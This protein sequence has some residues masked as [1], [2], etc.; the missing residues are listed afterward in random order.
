MFLQLH[1]PPKTSTTC[2]LNHE[3]NCSNYAANSSLFPVT[4]QQLTDKIST[5]YL[6]Y[7]PHATH[8][9]G[10]LVVNGDESLWGVGRDLTLGRRYTQ[11]LTC[12]AVSGHSLSLLLGGMPVNPMCHLWPQTAVP[13]V[14]RDRRSPDKH[15]IGNVWECIVSM[16]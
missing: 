11:H 5:I 16:I 2:H 3:H 6:H 8:V 1:P 9:L 14:S 7:A 10:K 12:N 15:Y 4:H 13:P